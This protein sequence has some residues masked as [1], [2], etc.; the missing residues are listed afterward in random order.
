[1]PLARP[2]PLPLRPPSPAKPPWWLRD[3]GGMERTSG[4][5]HV[6]GSREARIVGP[7]APARAGVAAAGGC[8]LLAAAVAGG[9]EEAAAAASGRERWRA[10]TPSAAPLRSS[11]ML[12]G[13]TWHSGKSR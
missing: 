11:L 12:G 6:V 5:R 1:M 4:L 10:G 8:T 7:G 2:P 9:A 13:R 3:G